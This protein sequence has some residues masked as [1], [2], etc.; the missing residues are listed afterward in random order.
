MRGDTLASL[1]SPSRLQ[2]HG[3]LPMP[4]PSWGRPSPD[5]LP[6]WTQGCPQLA[7][8]SGIPDAHPPPLHGHPHPLALAA[9][10]APRGCS[11]ARHHASPASPT[12]AC[13]RRRS[14]VLGQ[15]R[16][17]HGRGWGPGS[18]GLPGWRQRS[19]S[20]R[21]S[22]RQLRARSDAEA[23]AES[24]G[25]GQRGGTLSVCARRCLYLHPKQNN[26]TF[27]GGRKPVIRRGLF[28]AKQFL[29]GT[30]V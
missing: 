21:A 14:V 30:P 1:P 7:T 18:P 6:A 20:P 22:G 17:P 23:E 2:D 4:C 29:S 3:V 15:S 11:G 25:G 27:V 24:S 16:T 26:Y 8:P 12:P 10:A 9:A 28:A 5:A 13:A 19:R